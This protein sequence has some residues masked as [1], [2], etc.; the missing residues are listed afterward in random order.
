MKEAAQY[1]EKIEVIMEEYGPVV[2]DMGLLALR[3]D[4]ATFL[5]TGLVFLAFTLL[6]LVLIRHILRTEGGSDEWEVLLVAFIVL[7]PVCIVSA[8]IFLLNPWYWIGLFNPELYAIW[9]F[10]L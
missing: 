10:I 6:L 3:I 2:A 5:L 4:A 8:L 7:A 9:K 1:L